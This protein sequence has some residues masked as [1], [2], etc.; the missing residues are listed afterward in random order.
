MTHFLLLMTGCLQNPSTDTA[1]HFGPAAE[2]GATDQDG[3]RYAAGEDCDDGDASIHPGQPEVCDGRDDNCNGL[4]DEGYP[5]SDQDGTAD[6]V[7]REECDGLDNDGDGEVDEGYPDSDQDGA[8]DCTDGESCDGLDNDGDGLIDEGFDQDGDGIPPCG[9][10]PDCDDTDPDTH[11][12]ADERTDDTDNDCDGLIDEDRYAWGDLV[13][14]EIMVNPRATT[15]PSGEWLEIT[16]VTD[17]VRYLNGLQLSAG[18]TT[19]TV[20]AAPALPIVPGEILVLSASPDPLQNGGLTTVYAYSGLSLSNEGGR[21]EVTADGLLI[22]AASWGVT[23]GGR[24]LTLDPLGWDAGANDDPLWWCASTT[25]W[26]PESPSADAGSPG[27][28][29]ELCPAFD[30]DG[31]GYTG[32]DGDCDDAEDTIHPG[33]SEVW[34]DGVDQ[35][36]DGE[37]DQDADGDGVG[38]DSGDCDDDDAAVFPGNPERCDGIDNDCDGAVDEESVDGAWW[39]ADADGDGH[40]D[41]DAQ[42]WACEAPSGYS[43]LSDDCDD[44]DRSSSPSALEVC[45][46]GVDNDCDGAAQ[47]CDESPYSIG[48]DSWDWSARN[49]YRGNIYLAESDEE[50]LRF[51]MLLDLPTGG[52]DLTFMVFS[53]AS[54]TGTWDQ[55][56]AETRWSGQ[57]GWVSSPGIELEVAE[58]T[59]YS[60]GVGW[61]CSATYY[62]DYGSFIGD[63][64]GV[65]GFSGNHYD[66][67]Y[68]VAKGYSPSSIG[69][70]S[71][72]YAQVVYVAE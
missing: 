33:A 20:A 68:A 48:G 12:G 55:E 50:L 63:D 43:A 27:A 39:F 72:A 42:A 46:N 18:E 29:N 52:C 8:A 14:T 37:S 65:G 17:E 16:N 45:D 9:A 62:A 30:H 34:Y 51:E 24:S 49:Y 60:L 10:T 1:P 54:L 11:P 13:L 7:D 58:G 70:G 22:D 64:G 59:Y 19:H 66:N 56:W 21:L 4:A 41:A 57:D 53:A 35:D 38:A 25:P 69:S 2:A 31:D 23:S 3:D 61:T 40:G 15:D 6:C 67:A 26:E 32:A 44:G 71:F 5:D 28:V 47:Y 36:C